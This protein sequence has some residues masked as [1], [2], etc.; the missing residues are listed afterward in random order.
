MRIAAYILLACGLIVSGF[1]LFA[2]FDEERLKQR[3]IDQSTA[4]ARQAKAEKAARL[5]QE[6]EAEIAQEQNHLMD[7]N[8]KDYATPKEEE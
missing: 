7:L 1:G 8:E 2:L 6:L 5:K 4:I 3:R